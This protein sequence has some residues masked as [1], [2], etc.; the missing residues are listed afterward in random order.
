MPPRR[1]LAR[2]SNATPAR[3]TRAASSIRLTRAS[4]G[5]STSGVANPQLPEVQTQQSFAYGSTKTPLLP[6]ALKVRSRMT[7]A[8]M[9]QELDEEIV[10]AEA[11]LRAHVAET[12]GDRQSS[13]DE[14]SERA[15]RRSESRGSRESSV[16]SERTNLSHFSRRTRQTGTVDTFDTTSALGQIEEDPEEASEHYSDE[17]YSEDESVEFNGSDISATPALPDVT[18]NQEARHH[19]T[20][21]FDTILATP[22]RV[23]QRSVVVARQTKAAATSMTTCITNFTYEVLS[24]IA[25]PFQRMFAYS[26]YYYLEARQNRSF[27]ELSYRV[28][29]M[30]GVLG[31]VVAAFAIFFFF[32]FAFVNM[33]QA[34]GHVRRITPYSFNDIRNAI[35]VIPNPIVTLSDPALQEQMQASI[36]T[37][38][39]RLLQIDEKSSDALSQVQAI[40][41]AQQSLKSEMKSFADTLS[42]QQADLKQ[43]Y[44]EAIDEKFRR[45]EQMINNMNTRMHGRFGES[46]NPARI[47]YFSKGTGA[48]V[49]PYR[50]SP[51]K[52]KKFTLLQT[53][54]LGPL[55]PLS[56][57]GGLAKYQS[58]PPIE[59]L[60]SWEEQ[61]DCWC[62]A[63]HPNSFTQITVQTGRKIVPETIVVEHPLSSALT[64]AENTPRNMELWALDPRQNDIEDNILGA[65]WTRI[66]SFKYESPTSNIDGP[67]NIQEFNIPTIMR[68]TSNFAVRVLDNYGGDITCLYRIKLYGR[69]K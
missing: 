16:V 6:K 11:N 10:V 52:H 26:R 28:G 61:G 57:F 40:A 56:P 64:T 7:A 45:T 30:F 43:N 24:S 69:R 48:V 19:E 34:L 31:Y 18:Y 46:A 17:Q 49:E 29:Q 35:T 53:I 33:P 13:I 14:R 32:F 55:S 59:A 3:Q 1:S 2:Q 60:Q 42:R 38:N 12:T 58:N 20:G 50:T 9:A 22:R 39:T 63:G 27:N 36:D 54:F 8:E 67:G 4:P 65:G 21:I 23:R 37:F 47:N 62:S 41:K 25:Y 44:Q 51:T 15:R 5:P 66:A 68:P